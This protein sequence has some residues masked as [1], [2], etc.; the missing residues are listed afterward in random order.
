M[1]RAAT[2][3]DLPAL[4]RLEARC[5]DADRM[6]RRSFRRIIQHGHADL[7]VHADDTTASGYALVLYHKG[8]H[9]A[10]LYSIAVDPDARG[11]GIGKALLGA[12]EDAARARGCITMRLEIRI[13]NDSAKRLYEKSGYRVF[14]RYPD[15]Y[16]DHA[17]ALRMEKPLIRNIDPSLAAVPYYR[18]TTEFTCGP[19]ALLMAMH[20][21]DPGIPFDRRHELRLWRESTSIFMTSGH[22]GCGPKGLALAAHR[23]GFEVKLW[24]NDS[25]PMFLDSVRSEAKKEVMRL[26]HEEFSEALENADIEVEYRPVT[27]EELQEEFAAGGIPVV[28]ISSWRIYGERFPHWVVI[29]GFDNRFVYVHDPYIDDAKGKT[30]LDSIGMP[31]SHEEFAGMARYGRGAQRAA[32]VIRLPERT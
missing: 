9:L 19:S 32:L 22:G 14:G 26:V 21:L 8:T 20:A 17:D 10:R 3:D 1:I 28:L 2:L 5:F 16:E 12:A 30:A 4:E 25:E 6:S 24:L 11:G 29:T 31:I 23:R 27:R 13:D 7:L 15:Y 18:Q